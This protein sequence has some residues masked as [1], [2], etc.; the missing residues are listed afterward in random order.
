MQF[1]STGGV[2]PKVDLRTAVLNSLPSDRGLYM[3]ETIGQL[4]AS[5]IRDIE[6]FSFADLS[7][8]VAK[9]LL[10]GTLSDAD[11][12]DIIQDAIN[13]KAPVVRLDDQ[14]HLSL[15]HI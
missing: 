5:I 2:S 15:I 1:Y 9:V 6:K 12:S 7:Y 8:E 10:Q 13:F 4:D 3:P 14:L 11:L